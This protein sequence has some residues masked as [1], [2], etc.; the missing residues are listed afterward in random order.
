MAGRQGSKETQA[1]KPKS[2]SRDK[3]HDVGVAGLTQLLSIS[4]SANNLCLVSPTRVTGKTAGQEERGHSPHGRTWMAQATR[5]VLSQKS[6][7]GVSSTMALAGF[8]LLH[9]WMEAHECT[10]RGQQGFPHP[11][12]CPKAESRHS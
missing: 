7:C 11:G 12:V 1:L 9:A 5:M 10:A 8:L 4:P 2:I 6:Q 3:S